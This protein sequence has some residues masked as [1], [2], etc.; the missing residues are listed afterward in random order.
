VK[1]YAMTSLLE[2]PTA[3]ALLDQTTVTAAT[4]RPTVERL[5][6][7]LDRYR[8]HFLRSEQRHN[9][10]LVLRGK[11]SGLD[12]KT[13]EPLAREA[14]VPRRTI[15]QFVGEGCWDDAAV[16][17]ELQAHVAEQLG[18]ADGVLIVDGMAVPKKGT[19]SCGVARQW[20]GRLGKVD[21]C[22]VGV[23]LGYAAHGG[24]A[25]LDAQLYLPPEQ[26]ADRDHRQ[27]THVPA[28]VTF[29][30]KWRLALDLI[31]TATVP[32]GWVT[33]DDEFGRASAFREGL[34]S[35]RQRYVLDV[36]SN[37][38]VR[39]L[40]AARPA[41]TRV[42]PWQN[43]AAWAAR[44][45]ARAWRTI[46]VRDGEKGP[47]RVKAVETMVQAKD[48]D[49]KAGARERLVVLRSSEAQPRTW[50]VLS[51]ARHGESL[52]AV[53]RAQASRHRI[54][55][56]FAEGN[57]EIGLDHCEVRSWRG[58]QHH[59]TLSLLALW[60]LQVEKRRLGKKRQA[61]R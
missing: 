20:C 14:G 21:N 48:D 35:A 55:E 29:Q 31:A 28:A 56:L 26:A 38:L 18:H 54:E 47:L 8:P 23:Y 37:T 15:Q 24:H 9:A 7:F 3:Q 58:W 61:S 25:L 40:R 46:T 60:Y 11:L 16:R 41:G 2:H 43:V 57:G 4:L 53:V 27:K 52:T 59:V 19:E 49:G 1:D 17:A 39:D 30:E 42:P 51:N 50:Y 32:H 12:R 22:Q 44:Q 34:R 13:C 45:P 5:D 33:G 36:P 10:L 6:A